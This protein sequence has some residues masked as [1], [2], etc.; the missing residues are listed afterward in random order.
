MFDMLEGADVSERRS[1]SC[2]STDELVFEGEV[3]TLT[4]DKVDGSL[5]MFRR[6]VEDGVMV[7]SEVKHGGRR[8]KMLEERKGL[9]TRKRERSEENGVQYINKPEARQPRR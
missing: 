4:P 2:C 6:E 9:S 3:V 8:A 5:V 1:T 7:L